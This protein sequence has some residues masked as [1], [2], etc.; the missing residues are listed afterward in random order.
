MNSIPEVSVITPTKNRLALLRETLDSVA[1]QTFAA[2]EHIVV[3]DG[4]D[5]GTTEMM[6]SRTTSDPR[7]RYIVRQ[8]EHCGAN[9]C[10]NIG[11]LE[12]KAAFILFLDSDDLLEPGCLARR[13]EVIARNADI[14][15]ATFQTGVFVDAVGD[16]GRQMDDQL[17]GDDLA[18]FLYFEVPWPISAPI[19]R[20]A[21]LMKLGLFDERLLSWQDIE[22]HVRAL[23]AGFRYIRFPEIDHHVRWQFDLTKV[24]VEQRRAP[25]HL[26]A[27]IQVVETLESH[28]RAGPGMNWVRQRALCSLYFFIAQRWNERGDFNEALSAWRLVRSRSLGARSLH[29]SGM[30]LLTLARVR[31]PS[32]TLIRKWKGWTRLRTNPEV[33]LPAIPSR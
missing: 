16:L 19:W 24:S 4:S 12:A 1:A 21:S 32:E 9:V 25:R 14:D 30:L 23:T 3:D 33:V 27:A 17:L 20:R 5:D 11:V 22:L 6:A 13:L 10:R 29:L 8:G 31:L 7:V 18:R 2:W 28:V 26:R 15:F